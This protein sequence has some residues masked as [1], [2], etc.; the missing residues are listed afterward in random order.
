[1]N[2]KQ[3]PKCEIPDCSIKADDYKCFRGELTGFERFKQI[4]LIIG[5]NN[6]GKSALI[7]LVEYA[8][9]SSNSYESPARTLHNITATSATPIVIKEPFNIKKFVRTYL[10]S[11]TR[12]HDLEPSDFQ[13]N[14]SNILT[15]KSFEW[16][17]TNDHGH[18]KFSNTLLTPDILK[19]IYQTTGFQY[20]S[21]V[22][23]ST[24][25]HMCFPPFSEYSLFRLSADRN[26]ESDEKPDEAA[27][28][29]TVDFPQITS[30]GGG[31]SL[32]Y[33]LFK[34]QHPYIHEDRLSSIINALKTIYGRDG[35][36]SSITV[37][38]YFKDE[39]NKA[40]PLWG[41]ATQ[42]PGKNKYIKTEDSGSGLKT[43]LLTLAFLH[44]LPSVIKADLAKCI[45][46]FE[47]LENNLHPS[48]Q[49][50]LFKYLLDFTRDNGCMLF[51]TTHSNVAIDIFSKCSDEEAQIL[52]VTHDGT[53][54]SVDTIAPQ[55]LGHV[56]DDLGY[57]AS[58]ILQSNY[59]VWVEGPSDRIYVRHALKKDHNLD[60]GIHYST[61]FYG[62]RLLSHLDFDGTTQWDEEA[63]T[64][65]I[66]LAKIN[67][68]SAIVLDSD[69]SEES[70]HLN[71]TKIRIIEA[72]TDGDNDKCFAWVTAGREI[73]NYVSPVVFKE[74]VNA[75][76]TDTDWKAIT[77]DRYSQRT[78]RK[79]AKG[80]KA[81]IDKVKVA[82]KLCESGNLSFEHDWNEC[83]KKLAD[84]IRAANG[85]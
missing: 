68:N 74:A 67:R 8:T 3:R 23:T 79:E 30:A 63:V 31:I 22:F 53:N 2:E 50:R 48:V 7:D 69:K 27:S 57:Q 36:F 20:F 49:R 85:K 6:T 12:S 45:F 25:E 46:C 59:L 84:N 4:N 21:N 5:K 19:N 28:G 55:K 43:I 33:E 1:M 13:Q 47:E 9:P 10:Q 11:K 29:K 60:E 65:L 39:L 61:M 81:F 34:N 56:L 82:R 37:M 75:A 35:S 72:F 32:L 51:L 24:F 41:I 14:L 26:L 66:D 18:P 62:G 71:P 38:R 80:K 73:E 83:I 44:L 70:S 58:D 40:R 42:E 77:L 78:V 76:H 64:E 17:R 54:A 52:H 16:K 15:N